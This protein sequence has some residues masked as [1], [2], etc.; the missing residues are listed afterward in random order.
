MRA[1][2]WTVV[3]LGVALFVVPCV[4]SPARC[5]AQTVVVKSAADAAKMIA[6]TDDKEKKKFPDW[7]KVVEGAK[8]LEGLFP[9]YYNEKEQKLFMEI[10]Q[11]Q[12]DKEIILPIA[13]AKGAGL[14]YLGGATLNFGDQWLISFQRAGDRILVIRRNVRFRAEAGSPQA[15]A[16]K[17][18]YTDSVLKALPIKSEKGSSV[19]I[20]L[21]DLLMTD[22][23]NIGVSPDPSRSTWAKV[24]V[25][26]KNVEIEVSAVFSANNYW[27]WWFD[28]D[29]IPD[30][31]GA[32]VVIHYSMSMLPTSSYKPRLADDRVGH[33]LSVVR[34]FSQDLNKTP[35]VRY[36][37]RWNLEKANPEA[38]K[39]PPK[40]PIIFWIERSV[41]REYRQ[42][43]RDGI[44]EWNKAF[45]KIG[46]LDAIQVRDQQSDDEFDPEDIR[47]NTFRWI[48]TSAGFAMGPSRTNPKTGEILDADIVF[49]EGMIR[50][51]REQYLR[52]V[53]IPEGV[54]A[55]LAGQRRGFFRTFAAD[56]PT[57]EAFRPMLD[58]A[59][60]DPE[61]PFAQSHRHAPGT[62]ESAS[63]EPVGYCSQCQMGPGIQQQLAVLASVLAARGQLEPG[64]KIPEKFIA[65]AVKEVVMH[66]VGHTLG[67]RHNFKAS[68]ALTLDQVNDPGF[69]S[70]N[71]NSGS[72]MDYLPANISRKG[73]KQGDYFSPT[74][75]PYDYW[76]IEYAYK[77][78]KGDEKQELAK[79]A[80]KAAE[81]NLTFATDEDIWL[82]PDPRIN[83]YDLGDPLDFAKD[84]VKLVRASLDDLQNRVVAKGEGWQRARSAFGALMG[85]MARATWLSLSYIS[86]EY[87]SRDHRGDANSRPPVKPIDAAK[88]REALRLIQEEVLSDKAF[89]FKP[90]LLR[91][92]APDHW[93]DNS[94]RYYF[95]SPYHYP[96]LK[97]AMLIQ[98]MALSHLLNGETLQ[99]LQEASLL[100]DPGQEPLSLDEVFQALSDSVWSELPKKPGDLKKDQ[101]LVISILRRNLQREHVK[102][103]SEMVV[104][105]RTNTLWDIIMLLFFGDDQSVPA[106][107]RSLARQQLRQIDARIQ[108]LLDQKAVTDPQTAAHL[109]E[110]HDQIDKVFKASLQANRL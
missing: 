53:G 43:V 57:F 47:Y 7:D 92:L 20:D 78:V 23:P 89:Q 69:T 35:K 40:Q 67:L 34:D 86:G 58:R 62:D 21:A 94:W 4:F 5:S 70:K 16:V 33:F 107:A 95:Y 32:Q 90:E 14:S 106:D 109:E 65:Q 76:A 105:P 41:P 87:T 25:F 39:S 6:K 30:R 81:S 49:D 52:S 91:S 12:Y 85:E 110:I 51:W 61:G 42:Y 56:L 98:R 99:T 71:G 82:N 66:E 19:L 83:L 28:D 74:I 31:R 54:N 24:K 96:A 22:L 59:L 45:E 102:R 84:R 17:T 101:K 104:G 64:G 108:P 44:L 55:L 26:P 88:Q 27:W 75:G 13:I 77:P 2:R 103:L 15:D 37:T 9:L 46:F 68:S 60:A 29:S 50:F 11:S 73:E 79:I 72:I 48:T 18:S 10:Q 38:E 97:Y 8:R 93:Y 63:C 100:A 3:G 1:T 80:T 36:A